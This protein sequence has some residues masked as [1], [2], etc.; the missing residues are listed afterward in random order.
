MLS[1][2]LLFFEGIL[3]SVIV[4]IVGA[5]VSQDPGYIS[6]FPGVQL[7]F[8]WPF[9]ARIVSFG[10]L[11]TSAS[12]AVCRL[13]R[14]RSKVGPRGS[15]RSCKTRPCPGS[16]VADA[17]AAGAEGIAAEAGPLS[18]DFYDDSVDEIENGSL[19]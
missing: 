6:A 1:R 18:R 13:W 7:C 3:S 19:L 12:L 10:I 5:K 2:F 8:G 17:A 15:G 16:S 4:G 14:Q 9:M 11:L